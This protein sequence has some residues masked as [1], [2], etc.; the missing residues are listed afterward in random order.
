M[1]DLESLEIYAS[2]RKSPYL[3]VKHSSYFQVYEELLSRFKNRPITFVEVGILHG[4]SLFMWRDYLGP[5]ARIIG[6]DVD[7]VARRWES[8]GFEIHIGDQGDPRFWDGFFSAVGD[9]DVL[10]DDGGHF[11]DQQIVTAHGCIPHIRDG[12]MLIV[13]D[14]HASYLE[15]Y[16]NPSRFSFINFSKEMIDRIN[17]RC[18]V[19]HK[20]DDVYKNA[21]YSMGIYESIVCFNI[22][23]GK[24]FVSSHTSNEGR[25]LGAQEFSKPE[26]D[27]VLDLQNALRQRLSFL[28]W[29]APLRA[30]QRFAF[31]AWLSLRARIGAR[32]LKK[33][34]L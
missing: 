5:E 7:P 3:S 2:Y 20:S 10:L 19:L 6:I 25:P 4:G 11:N 28:K 17:S 23:R 29:I 8:S 34:F 12:G 15:F 18:A 30:A 26:P 21:V 14:T 27:A 33:Y 32:K 13:E 31:D 9:V 16:R 1:P 22:D 24:C